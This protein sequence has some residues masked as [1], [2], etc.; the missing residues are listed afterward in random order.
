MILSNKIL[1]NLFLL[2]SISATFSQT[3]TISGVILNDTNSPIEN[4]TVTYGNEGTKTS[5]DGDF[6]IKI[7]ANKEIIITFSHISFK[8]VVQTFNLNENESYE[9]NPVLNYNQ[10]QLGTV[11]ITGDK[12]ERVEG[13]TTIS[14]KMLRKIPGGNA[15]VENILKTLAGVSGN[16]ELSS[17]YN[18][19]GGNFDENLVY[20]NEIEIYRPFLVRSGQQEGLSF[21]NSDL[22]SN[23]DFSAGG[24]QAKYGDKLSSVL[25][26]SYKSPRKFGASLD[27]NLLG[28]SASIEATSENKKFSGILGVR[29]RNNSLFV[30]AKE[31][32]TNYDPKFADI[33]TFFTYKISKKLDIN[34]LSNIAINKYN[35]QPKTR[36]T[37]FGTLQDP[38]ALIVYYNGQEKD[39]Y[40]SYFGAVKANYKLNEKLTLKLIGSA[41]H[42]IE[43]EYFDI[44]AEY[45]LGDVNSNIGDE[46]FGEVEFS[47]GIGSQLNHA[48][49]DLDAL[50][51]SF[52]HKGDYKNDQNKYYWGVKYNYEN[53]RDKIIEWE[54]IDSTGFSVRPPG[55]VTNN[56]PYFPYSGPL[57]PFQNVRAT[58]DVTI[59]RIAAFAQ[60]NREGMLGNH[61]IFF[62]AGVR[63]HNWTVSGDNIT[64]TS[65]IVFSPRAQ[66]SIKP[67]WKKDMIF[68]VASGIYHQPPFYRELRDPNG[69]VNPNVKAQKSTHFIIGGDYNFKLW[70]RPFKF[71]SDFY[72]KNLSNI[73]TY[74]IDNVR[75]RYAANNNAKGYATGLDLRL[76]GE[77]V[78]GTE[79]WF[80]FGYLKTEENID[81][82]GY[83]SRPTDQRLKFGALFQDYMPNLPNIKVY[84]NLV[85]NTGVPGGSPSYADAYQYQNRLPAYKRADAGFSYVIVDKNKQ[86]D[87]GH[88]FHRLEEFQI[89]FEIFNMFDVQNSITNTWVRDVYSKQQFAVPNYLTPRIFNVR[90]GL[91]F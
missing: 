70:K 14:P 89:G 41:Y 61:E 21:I 48:R 46:N 38:K 78:S 7:P 91:K 45:R 27:A 22:V 43:E 79:S 83:I 12:R 65:Q 80:S 53:I 30:N 37:N 84:I 55:S 88:L 24:F 36:Q 67:D 4:V 87:K 15:G 11:I 62:N 51:Y 68:R 73:N 64:S 40:N 82:K 18:V 63:T 35:Y 58:N 9:F 59:N 66:F 13:I 81:N 19:R 60:Y 39:Q 71:S 44:F 20:V 10:E 42:T 32:E 29:Y 50:I 17:Q 86:F 54:V 52:E 6:T 57:V 34:F 8:Q 28:G 49:N 56:Q 26:I 3:A 85:Y 33:Q 16:N 23:V 77:F 1:L 69:V 25:D 72:Y 2:F 90:M 31:T 75:I 76:N 5:K 47:E 74:T